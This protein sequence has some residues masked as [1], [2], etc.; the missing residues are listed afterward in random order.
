MSTVKE[1]IWILHFN[2]NTFL[3]MTVKYILILNQKNH[4]NLKKKMKLI[5]KRKETEMK[6]K[7]T[8]IH[9]HKKNGKLKKGTTE[10]KKR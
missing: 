6:K 10:P 7:L 8:L 9:F 1:I 4:Q 3:I 5:M 2:V